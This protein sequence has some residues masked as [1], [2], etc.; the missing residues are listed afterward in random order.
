MPEQRED[1]TILLLPD[2]ILTETI[3]QD[4]PACLISVA[5]C[6][7]KLWAATLRPSLSLCKECLTSKLVTP[8]E[9]SRL[10]P[11][12]AFRLAERFSGATVIWEAPPPPEF[13]EDSTIVPDSGA[14]TRY[15][16]R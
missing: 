15:A 14:A 13:L 9:A 3:V 11:R 8:A 5:A 2:E 10:T 6:A 7:C 16:R 4:L 12:R 1:L